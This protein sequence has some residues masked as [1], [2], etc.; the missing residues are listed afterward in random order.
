V[1]SRERIYLPSFYAWDHANNIS[2]MLHNL[3][4]VL[5]RTGCHFTPLS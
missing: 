2:P 5:A 1:A 4:Q 3:Y